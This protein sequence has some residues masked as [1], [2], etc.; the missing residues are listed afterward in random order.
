MKSIAVPILLLL[1]GCAT[2]QSHVSGLQGQLPEQ[3]PVAR[4]RN[5][6][7]FNGISL[8]VPS[9]LCFTERI[10]ADFDLLEF[11]DSVG[12]VAGAYIGTAGNFPNASCAGTPRQTGVIRAEDGSGVVR[13]EDLEGASC[14]EIGFRKM[15]G[16][17]VSSGVLMHIW[18]ASS[19][20]QRLKL[21]EDMLRTIRIGPDLKDDSV[22]ANVLCP[23]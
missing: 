23:A 19:E 12:A 6:H 4:G 21:I 2:T 14:R 9:G 17:D 18:L 1:V 13:R 20:P 16:P 8:V 10:Q 7:F 3:A 15:Y 5:A 22:S 11:K